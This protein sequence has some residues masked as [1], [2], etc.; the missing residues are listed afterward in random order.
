MKASLCL[1]SALLACAC[2]AGAAP[3]PQARAVPE[4]ELAEACRALLRAP[5]SAT[6][7]Q[8]LLEVSR[9]ADYQAELRCRAMAAFALTRLMQLDTNGFERARL[10]VE[11]AYPGEAGRLFT[12]TRADAFAPCEACS[13]KGLQVTAC[14]TCRGL[15]KCKACDA[16]GR[17]DDADCPACKGKGTC[18]RCAGKRLFEAPCPTCLGNRQ[19][20]K[21]RETIRANYT[22]LLSG[23][24]A[25]VDENARFAEQFRAASR[26]ANLDKRIAL[27]RALL[28][29]FSR[30]T[31]LGPAQALLAETA[32]KRHSEETVRL[33]RET[34]EREAKDLESLRQLAASDDLAGSVA[35]LSAY[36][37]EHPKA[38]T[39]LELK[40][41]LD[42]QLDK[43]RRLARTRN[44][45]TGVGAAI[46]AVFLAACLRPLLTCK[47]RTSTGPLPGMDKINMDDFTDPLTLNAKESKSRVK[48]K[49][50]QITP[51]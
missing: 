3:A 7:L 36:L 46:G 28:A 20:F 12:V 17:K 22:A 45:L 42:E 35:R 24:V 23:I 16:T 40:T 13:G 27:L 51:P 34:R 44:I 11:A 18:P 26:E 14:P 10:A 4:T 5:L 50:D 33:A 31:D 15:G 49:T 2:A 9:R 6:D 47:P 29:E 32:N 37:T 8:V 48:T 30:R 41:L 1:A 25:A 19:V 43:R 39:Y 21:P 38:S